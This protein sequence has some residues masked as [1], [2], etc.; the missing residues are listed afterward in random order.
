MAGIVSDYRRVILD[1]LPPDWQHYAVYTAVGLVVPIIGFK[2][3]EGTKKSFAD[4][5]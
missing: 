2:F 3:F 5:M 4:V 1:G